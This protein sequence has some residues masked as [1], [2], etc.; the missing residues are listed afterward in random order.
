MLQW[1]WGREGRGGIGRRRS[2]PVFLPGVGSHSLFPG[3]FPTHGSNLV[4]LHCRQIL[5]H[6]S[7]KG[8][9]TVVLGELQK[10]KKAGIELRRRAVFEVGWV[11]R[12]H[13]SEAV[14]SESSDI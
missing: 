9:P 1:E 11:I 12:D 7:H 5:Y 4:L 3:I 2:T 10:I 13:F 14:T 6:L 8:S